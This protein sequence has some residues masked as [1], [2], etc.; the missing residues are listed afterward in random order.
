MGVVLMVQRRGWLR[1][2]VCY[3]L[4]IGVRVQ[5][6][7]LEILEF[8]FLLGLFQNIEVYRD[9]Y[10]FNNKGKNRYLYGIQIFKVGKVRRN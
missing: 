4:V 5:L 9:I 2:Q 3:E 10:I 1:D 7:Y 6:D 8:I